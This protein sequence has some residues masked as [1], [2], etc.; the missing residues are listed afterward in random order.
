MGVLRTSQGDL[1][2]FVNGVSQVSL[3]LQNYLDFPKVEWNLLKS[4]PQG[5][6]ASNLPTTVFA[7]IDMYGKCAQVN[8]FFLQLLL[9]KSS[10]LFS[11]GFLDG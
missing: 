3:N 1:L 6:A 9:Q 7:V 8:F 5:V 10:R 2:F 11:S 4:Y